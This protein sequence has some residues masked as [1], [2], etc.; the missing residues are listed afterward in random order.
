MIAEDAQLTPR[1]EAQ[2]LN[3]AA[4]WREELSADAG[5]RLPDAFFC[6]PLSRTLATCW[7]TSGEIPPCLLAKLQDVC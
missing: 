5:F 4:V 3:A 1:G 7:H 6:S 2:A